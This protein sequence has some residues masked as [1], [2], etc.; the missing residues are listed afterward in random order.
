M[1]LDVAALKTFN[2][3]LFPDFVWKISYF[4]VLKINLSDLFI[5]QVWK[6]LPNVTLEMELR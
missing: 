5:I 1:V 3:L 4:S 2:L 6:V